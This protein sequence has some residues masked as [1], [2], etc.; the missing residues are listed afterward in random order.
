MKRSE[1]VDKL[2]Q[3]CREEFGLANFTYPLEGEKLLAFI[4]EA[5]MQPPLGSRIVQRNIV[6]KWAVDTGKTQIIRVVEY[7]WDETP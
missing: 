1:M 3:F 5:G 2:Q 4:E 6:D 7:E